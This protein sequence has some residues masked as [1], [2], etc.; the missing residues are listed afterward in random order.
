MAD[1]LVNT[2]YKQRSFTGETGES[3]MFSAELTIMPNVTAWGGPVITDLDGGFYEAAFT[4]NMDGV[5]SYQFTGATS[6]ATFSD[7]VDI[8]PAPEQKFTRRANGQ[9]ILDSH[10][11]ELQQGIEKALTVLGLP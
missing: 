7:L 10:V 11:N 9:P 5:W 8:L 1:G 6:G 4:P 3:F 2:E